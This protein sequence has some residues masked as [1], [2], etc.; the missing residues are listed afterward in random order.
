[1]INK[2]EVFATSIKIIKRLVMGNK[3]LYYDKTLFQIV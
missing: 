1:M 2:Y 3:I